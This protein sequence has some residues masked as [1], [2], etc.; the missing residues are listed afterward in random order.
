MRKKEV[1]FINN[2]EMKFLLMSKNN[3]I[4]FKFLP[5]MIKRLPKKNFLIMNGVFR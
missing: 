1:H 2:I 4:M 5:V 3:K